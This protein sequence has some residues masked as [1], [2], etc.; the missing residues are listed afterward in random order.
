MPVTA[1][2]H[3]KSTNRNIPSDAP[4]FTFETADGS[5]DALTKSNWLDRCNQIWVATGFEPLKA[6]AFHIGGCTK[7]LLRGIQPDIVCIQGRW[8]SM[9]FLA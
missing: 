1:L 5:W 2:R 8:K 4:L 7:M 9:S 6:Y 3:H